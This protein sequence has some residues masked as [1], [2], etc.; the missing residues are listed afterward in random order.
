MACLESFLPS[1]NHNSIS[2]SWWAEWPDWRQI[3]YIRRQLYEVKN[4]PIWSLCP[5]KISSQNGTSH[6]AMIGSSQM[7]HDRE[8]PIKARTGQVPLKYWN[9]CGEKGLQW[10]SMRIRDLSII[11]WL[12]FLRQCTVAIVISYPR[13]HI[14]YLKLLKHS[15][16]CTHCLPFGYALVWHIRTYWYW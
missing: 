12:K 8:V 13:L 7:G 11:G 9:F 15:P 4:A 6:R 16:A 14:A 5:S 2:F 1:C 3:Y 10:Y